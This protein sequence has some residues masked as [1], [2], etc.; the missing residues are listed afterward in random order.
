M[1]N[2]LNEATDQ[3]LI[4]V[5]RTERGYSFES[6][7]QSW[8]NLLRATRTRELSELVDE[9]EHCGIE[10]VRSLQGSEVAH[11]LQQDEFSARN[12]PG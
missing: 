3:E 1:F 9:C 8:M 4:C 7:L 2:T 11:I 12:G 10:Q 5:E 6:V